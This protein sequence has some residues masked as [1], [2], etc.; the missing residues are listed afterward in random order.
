MKRFFISLACFF[1]ACAFPAFA[2]VDSNNYMLVNSG[3]YNYAHVG[4]AATTV[5]KTG[6]GV[7]HSITV[8]T[9]GTVASVITIYDNTSAAGSVIAIINSLSLF[10]PFVYDVK[11]TTGLTIVTTGT[12][13]P[14]VTISYR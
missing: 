14:D 9:L 6:P 1:I 10:G 4:S 8:N 12:L 5:I 3:N 7:L 2:D 13:A 11:F